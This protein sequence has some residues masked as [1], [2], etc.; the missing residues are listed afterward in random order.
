MLNEVAKGGGCCGRAHDRGD[1]NG[2][3][4]YR[5]PSPLAS[6]GIAG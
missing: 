6:E 1:V 2:G 3:P 5:Q 4:T